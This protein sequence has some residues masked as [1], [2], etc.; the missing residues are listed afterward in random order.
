MK[1]SIYAGI[2]SRNTPSEV[3]QLMNLIARHRAGDWTLRSGGALGADWA[4]EAGCTEAKGKKEIFLRQDCTQAA[5]IETA[6]HCPWWKNCSRY[7]RELHGRNAMIILGAGLQTPVDEVICWTPDGK[8][9]GGTGQGIR[10]AH[11]YDIPVYNLYWEAHR[12]YWR[13]QIHT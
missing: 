2:G 11:A 5:M 12:N 7:T 9:T 6:R 1:I 3:L 10:I 13:E 8:D 4:F